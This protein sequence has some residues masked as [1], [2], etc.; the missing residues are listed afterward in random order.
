M[1][2]SGQAVGDGS[3]TIVKLTSGLLWYATAS[4]LLQTLVIGS[5]LSH[6][7]IEES[8]TG[9]TWLS[10]D[11]WDL[12][13]HTMFYLQSQSLLSKQSWNVKPAVVLL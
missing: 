7:V 9:L 12:A 1:T 6:T 5:S 11:F 3:C 8:F 4:L 10:C 2:Q 13:G